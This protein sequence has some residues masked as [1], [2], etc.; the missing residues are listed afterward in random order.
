MDVLEF[1]KKLLPA[2]RRLS[3]LRFRY[4]LIDI[5]NSTVVIIISICLFVIINNYILTPITGLQISRFWTSILILAVLS[6]IGV[7]LICKSFYKVKYIYVAKELD[8][9]SNNHN[10]ISTAFEYIESGRD[11]GFAQIAI[12]QGIDKLNAISPET[13]KQPLPAVKKL[14]FLIVCAAIFASFMSIRS[15]FQQSAANQVQKGIEG[16]NVSKSIDMSGYFERG[17]EKTMPELVN[18]FPSVG[19]QATGQFWASNASGQTTSGS[20]RSS[21]TLRKERKFYQA[22]QGDA[23]QSGNKNKMISKTAFTGSGS[24]ITPLVETAIKID[25]LNINAGLDE[26]QLNAKIKE[27]DKLKDFASSSRRPFTDDHRA[28]PGRELGRSGKK[29]KPDNGRGGLGSIK[30]SR[31]TAALFPGQMMTVHVPSRPGKGKSKSFESNSPLQSQQ[32]VKGIPLSSGNSR[33][34]SIN[35]DPIKQS[36]KKITKLYFEELNEQSNRM[37]R[38]GQETN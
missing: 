17:I 14:I 16:F 2:Q 38:E 3:Q 22:K 26:D 19:T 10:M 34:S 12:F 29:G 28:A 9:V 35:I 20:S 25:F 33:E 7:W 1:H 18:L 31:S 8:K 15:G 36:L 23:V 13:L 30:K 27:K 11:S 37:L 32:N 21:V 24:A 6:V 4:V 5:L